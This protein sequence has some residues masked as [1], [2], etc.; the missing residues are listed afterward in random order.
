MSYAS[1]TLGVTVALADNNTAG[2]AT[3]GGIGTDTLYGIENVTGGSGNDVLTG[4]AAAKQLDG[5]AGATIPI[6]GGT[7]RR[8][9]DPGRRVRIAGPRR[10]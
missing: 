9:T 5:A 2:T 7:G 8:H 3:G 10:G 1:T 4:N 6:S